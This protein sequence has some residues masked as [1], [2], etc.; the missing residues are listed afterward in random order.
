MQPLADILRKGDRIGIAEDLN[1][2]A[3]GVDNQA[4]VRAMGEVQLEI[5]SHARVEDSVEIAR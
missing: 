5:A 2:L 1:G 4:A 3:A